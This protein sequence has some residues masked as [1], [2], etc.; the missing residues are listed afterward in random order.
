MAIPAPLEVDALMRQV[1][2]GKLVTINRLRDVLAR[3]HGATMACPMTTGIFAWIAA[4]A[5]ADEQAAGRKRVTPWWRTL[6]GQGELN[7]KFPGGVE[8]QARLLRAEGH[9]ILPA[10][11]KKPPQV[12]D[13]EHRLAM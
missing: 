5:A 13:V 7:P 1:P 12:A 8:A 6:K 2:K 10:K 4:H 9:T 3:R 11:G